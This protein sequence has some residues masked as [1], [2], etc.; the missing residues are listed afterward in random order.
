MIQI[1]NFFRIYPRQRKF[2]YI[3]A[4]HSDSVTFKK[5]RPEFEP[6][7]ENNFFIE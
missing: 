1:P 4:E 6:Q 5:T 7:N 3:K 2:N